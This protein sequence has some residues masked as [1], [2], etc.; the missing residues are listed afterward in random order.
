[1]ARGKKSKTRKSRARQ[2]VTLQ[3]RF[4]QYLNEALAVENAA[5]PRL[6]ARIRQTGIA[7]AKG[8]L[9][10]HLEET[11]EQ[12]SR[13]QQV[14]SSLGGKPAREQ[15][16][17]PIPSPPKKMSSAMKLVPAEQ[18]LKG[19]KEDA[20]IENAEVVMYDTLVQLAQQANMSEAIPALTQNLNEEKE[21][22]DWIRANTPAMIA[23]LYPQIESSFGR[24][25]QQEE[26]EV[27]REEQNLTATTEA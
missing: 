27:E 21:M 25:Q 1:M 16:Q 5:V 3:E 7:E 15:A 22:A 24:R 11:R 13:L 10:H 14:I 6:E 23:Q 2:A 4:V 8:Q 18:E 26:K 17:L 9:Q 12:Q 20:I 19:A